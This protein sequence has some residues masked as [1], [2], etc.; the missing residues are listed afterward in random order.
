MD[1]RYL[2]LFAGMLVTFVLGSVHAYSVFLVPLEQSLDLPRS[3]VSLIYSWALVSI[4]V[5]VLFGYRIYTGLPSWLM[6]GLT[7]LLA[8]AG[9][10]LAARAQGWWQL[11]FGYSLMFGL[12]NGVGYGYSL[13][14]VGRVMPEIKGFAMG[15]VTA[16][17]ALGSILFAKIFAWRIEAVAVDAALLALM[18]AVLGFGI[19]AA[20][21][22]LLTGASYGQTDAQ[23]GG[24][25]QW[26]KVFQFWFAYMSSV[27]SGL[28]A[29]GHA[30]GIVL[31]K[32]LDSD[33]ATLGAMM[34]GVGS[35]LGGFLAGWMIDRWS[36]TRFLV[37]LPL[38]ASAALL[39]LGLVDGQ[40]GVIALL[41]IVG[42][43]YGSIIAVYPVAIS[44]YFAEAGPRVYGQVFTAWGF[45]GLVAPWTAGLIFDWSGGYTP[46]LLA[47][48][49]MAGL[50]AL[51][52]GICRF[53]RSTQRLTD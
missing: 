25:H 41:S 37:G 43:S 14:L 35:A 16:S 9:L 48:A 39:L 50:S 23:V 2:V 47:A 27:F 20:L 38:I 18:Y 5:S 45:A 33:Q 7:C 13:Q 53:E 32:N 1:K 17:Y 12:A 40:V 3:Q 19:T 36:V 49:V 42:F 44:N 6:T 34:I 31:W 21:I 15:A 46:A 8:A 4:T 28:M 52:A 26:R 22:L 29:I 11:F 10:L 24:R 51:V 30:A